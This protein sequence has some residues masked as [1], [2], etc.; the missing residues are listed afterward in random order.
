MPPRRSS[1]SLK[2]SRMIVAVSSIAR[3]VDVDGLPL[4]VLAKDRVGIFE[5]GSDVIAEPVVGVVGHPELLEPLPPD[6][7]QEVH[8]DGQPDDLVAGD[9]V[10]LLRRLDAEDDG[11]VRDLEPRPAR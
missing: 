11:D 4:R 10:Q 5:L 9:L 2:Y 7:G 3:F 8:L 1:T 6:V